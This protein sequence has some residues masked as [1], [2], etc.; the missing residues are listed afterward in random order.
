MKLYGY[1][2]SSA[3]WRVR[4][5][6]EYL[7]LQY[8]YVPVDLTKGEQ[9]DPSYMKINASS[10]VPSLV[11]DDGKVISQSVA[12][13]E[14][15]QTLATP[16]LRLS[17]IDPLERARAWE[18]GM[19]IACDTHPLQNLRELKSLDNVSERKARAQTVIRRGLELVEGVLRA[20]KCT[21]T[22]GNVSIKSLYCVGST[23]SI[24]D[25]CLIPQVYNARR[26]GI[27]VDTEFPIIA[28]IDASLS[29]LPVFRRAH[30]NH[31]VDAKPS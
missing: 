22:L 29:V 23:L 20:A 28:G 27:D 18:I 12:I 30:P 19:I 31:Q 17:P 1:W 5:V 21:Q 9:N 26:W 13:I 14:Y 7:E 3:T 6:L 2:R 4:I 10:L 11:L 24:A 25:V 8:E 16:A 15:L